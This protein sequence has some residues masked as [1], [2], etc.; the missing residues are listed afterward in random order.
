V[1]EAVFHLILERIFQEVF[2]KN[3]VYF[4]A[5]LDLFLCIWDF[6]FSWDFDLWIWDFTF[7]I[8]NLHFPISNYEGY[9][10]SLKNLE[11]TQRGSAPLQCSTQKVE[12]SRRDS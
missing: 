10:I 12:C 6:V 5:D 11:K 7:K 9:K 4:E 8:S 1:Q 3:L 2:L